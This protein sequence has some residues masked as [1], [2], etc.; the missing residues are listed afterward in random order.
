MGHL[1]SIPSILADV[2]RRVGYCRYRGDDFLMLLNV[3]AA[4]G[5]SMDWQRR[6]RGERRGEEKWNSKVES[7]SADKA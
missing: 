2:R 1:L 4:G 5:G 3:R 7:K 6:R